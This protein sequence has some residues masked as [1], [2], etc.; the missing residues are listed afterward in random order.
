MELR[1]GAVVMLASGGGTE[2]DLHD[3]VFLRSGRGLEVVVS[4]KHYRVRGKD[5]RLTPER[6]EAGGSRAEVE[7]M[8][9]GTTFVIQPGEALPWPR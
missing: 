4:G 2:L 1:S 7:P 8:G 3:T 6:I 9:S 5:V